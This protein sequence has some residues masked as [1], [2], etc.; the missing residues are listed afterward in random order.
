MTQEVSKQLV[1]EAHKHAEEARIVLR[2]LRLGALNELKTIKKQNSLK[3]KK[4][5]IRNRN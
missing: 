4:K 1:K 5:R 3:M 2:N